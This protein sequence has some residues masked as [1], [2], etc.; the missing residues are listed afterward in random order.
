[1]TMNQKFLRNSLLCITISFSTGL[2]AQEYPNPFNYDNY[3]Q[4]LIRSNEDLTTLSIID[5]LW[6]Y[7]SS[8]VFKVDYPLEVN[9]GDLNG[10]LREDLVL[11]T[12]GNFF[13]TVIDDNLMFKG[14]S[15]GVVL[16]ENHSGVLESIDRL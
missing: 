16:D 8:G 6:N 4:Y 9:T 13:Y 7:A 3:F 2:Q 15:G 14:N 12:N 10:D 1:M 11:L 5:T